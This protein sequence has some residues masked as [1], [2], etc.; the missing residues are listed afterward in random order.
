M[1]VRLKVKSGEEIQELCKFQFNE[2]AIK[3]SSVRFFA[4]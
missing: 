4:I 2:C 1:N 3:S